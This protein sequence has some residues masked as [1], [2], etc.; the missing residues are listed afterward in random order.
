MPM[1]KLHACPFLYPKGR[2]SF[3]FSFLLP[4]LRWSLTLYA[5]LTF[6]LK[7]SSYFC[8]PGVGITDV[9]HPPPPARVCFPDDVS[10]L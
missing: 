5:R 4:F 10:S 6:N 3:S 1:G 9:C 7:Q 8:F 2:F